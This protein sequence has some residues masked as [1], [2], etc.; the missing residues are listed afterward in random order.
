MNIQM[1]QTQKDVSKIELIVLD[2]DGTMT[3]GSIYL[4]DNGIETKKFCVKDG[5]GIVLAQ[6]AGIDFMILTGRESACVARR[7]QELKIR[8][9]FQGI[10][11]K[12]AHLQ[13]FMKEHQLHSGQIAYVGDD[14]NDLAAMQYA[15]ITVC[16]ADASDD[17][18]HDCDIVLSQKGGEGAVRAFVEWLLKQRNLWETAVKN[19]SSI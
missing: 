9:V 8:W 19:L 4:S 7:A 6:T 10:R 18:Q 1:V 5:C 13:Q 15:G 17:M 12:A 3:D 11:N 16:P 14:V 2:V